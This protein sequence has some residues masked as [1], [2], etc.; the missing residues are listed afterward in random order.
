MGLRQAIASVAFL[1][2]SL[3]TAQAADLWNDSAG[4]LK[5]GGFNGAWIVTLGGY[6]TAE[7]IYPGADGEIASFRPIIDIHRAGAREWLNLPND[8]GS[9]TLYSIDGRFRAGAAIDWLNDRN[10]GD[11]SAIRALHDINYTLE[12]GGFAEYYPTPSIRTRVELLQ[13]VTGA[14]GLAANFAADWIYQPGPKW[15]FTVGPRLRAVNTQFQS[16]FFSVNAAEAR[17]SNGL[18]NAYHA[19]GGINETGIDVTARYQVNDRL[20]LRAFGEWDRLLGDAADSP[21]TK[22]GS[23]DQFQ[24]GIGAAYSFNY[25]NGSLK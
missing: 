15:L 12:L 23:E 1:G 2:V 21:I 19:S 7:P 14:E 18:Y 5:D 3:T 4:S 13:G 25:A 22:R 20:S 17:D 11:D 10:H 24:V 16:E 8:A 9:I 6:V